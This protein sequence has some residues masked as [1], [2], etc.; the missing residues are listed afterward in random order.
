MF[1]VMKL[2]DTLLSLYLWAVFL[3]VAMT[4]LV[5]LNVINTS[6]QF[7]RTVGDFLYRITE[8]VLRRI[9]AVIP[10]VGGIDLSPFI[11]MLA[12]WFARNLLPGI[13]GFR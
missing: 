3:S 4:W 9:R 6:N 12:I 10:A 1:A 13:F 11:L 7:V 5:Q 2:I 8:P